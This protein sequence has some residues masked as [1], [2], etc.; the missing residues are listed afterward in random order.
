[1]GRR[2]AWRHSASTWPCCI[3]STPPDIWRDKRLPS[4][5]YDA[6]AD[7]GDPNRFNILLAD[8]SFSVPESIG[9]A[10]TASSFASGQL[11]VVVGNPPWGFPKPIDT[12]GVENGKVALQVVSAART[13]GGRP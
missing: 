4:L 8:N 11:D 13:Q 2:C 6:A 5:T 1:M 12:W 7:A 9:N 10:E 3:T